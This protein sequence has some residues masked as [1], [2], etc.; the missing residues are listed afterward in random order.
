MSEKKTPE[1]YGWWTCR[2]TVGP[3]RP[4]APGPCDAMNAPEAA[5]CPFCGAPRP[6]PVADAP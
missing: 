6:T 4:Y 3:D 1:E 2:G 5:E